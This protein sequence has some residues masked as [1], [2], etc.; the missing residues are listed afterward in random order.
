MTITYER[1]VQFLHYGVEGMKWGIRRYQNADGT[2][3]P[4]GRTRAGKKA[5]KSYSKA[6]DAAISGKKKK[7]E[8]SMKKFK[9]IDESLPNPGADKHAE[10]RE[11]R[12]FLKQKKGNDAN[13]LSD[14]TLNSRLS[15]LRNE[16][17]YKRAMKDARTNADIERGKEAT[18]DV[19][20]KVGKTTA[21]ALGTSLAVY[22]GARAIA[23]GLGVK[24]PEHDYDKMFQWAK[25]PKK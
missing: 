11:N 19:I 12:A 3:T 25:P 16:K 8:K 15:R 14:K 7:Y 10:E 17:D 24:T 6:A 4:L 5:V 23:S 22:F 13:T 2:L 1:N 9:K 20:E 21:T 18:K